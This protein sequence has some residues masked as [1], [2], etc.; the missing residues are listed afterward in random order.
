MTDFNV[1]FIDDYSKLEDLDKS[2]FVGRWQRAYSRGI[3]EQRLEKYDLVFLDF[4]TGELLERNIIDGI[5][6]R[7][8]KERF[9]LSV[10]EKSD[11]GRIGSRVRE[12][13]AGGYLVMPVEHEQIV[14][15]LRGINPDFQLLF[16]N[17]GMK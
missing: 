4:N 16:L 17:S 13:N 2:I 7:V 9:Y 14:E 6:S 3:L 12:W 15:I 10:K 1:L 5:R 8:S 11:E